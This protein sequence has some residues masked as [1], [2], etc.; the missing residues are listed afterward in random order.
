MR[1]RSNKGTGRRRRRPGRWLAAVCLLVPL[2]TGCKKCAATAIEVVPAVVDLAT[3]P[4]MPT[5]FEVEARLW[6]GPATGRRSVGESPECALT[7]SASQSWLQLVSVDGQRATFSIGKG[8]HPATPA[9]VKVKAGE[10]T[11]TPGAEVRVVP[12]TIAGQDVVSE[13]YTAG[14]SPAAVVVNGDRAASGGSPDV[15]LSAFVRTATPG[16]AN[17]SGGDPAWGVAV[18]DARHAMTMVPVTWTPSGD[19]VNVSSLQGSPLLLPVVLRVIIGGTGDLTALRTQVLNTAL[20]DISAANVMLAEN[21]VGVALEVKD[22]VAVTTSDALTKVSDC[23]AG[24]A[25]TDPGDWPGTLH[26]TYVNTMGSLTGF[27]CAGTDARPQSAIYVSWENHSPTTFAHEVGHA[28]GLTVPGQ[29]HSDRLAGFDATNLMT[30]G[31]SDLDPMGR[32]RFTV[33]QAFRMNAD[34]GSWLNRAHDP[35]T[36]PPVRRQEAPRL[37]CQCDEADPTHLCPRQVEDVAPPSGS[38]GAFNPWDCHDQ[39][40]LPEV[41]SGEDPVGLLAGRR[42]R[43]EIGDCSIATQRNWAVRFEQTYLEFDNMTRPGGCPSW[44]AIFF[45]HHEVLYRE[46]HESPDAQ[47][48]DATEQLPIGDGILP[49]DAGGLPKVTVTVDL[50]YKSDAASDTRVDAD[51]AEAGRVF[52]EDNRSGIVLEFS[53]HTSLPAPCPP[54]LSEGITV[55]YSA[56]V[57]GEG[58]RS[59]R[60]IQVSAD[61]E[62]EHT[63]SH[64]LGQ[65]LGLKALAPDDPVLPLN[66]MRRLPE[67]RGDRLTLG[68]VFRINAFLRPTE[69]PDCASDASRCPTLDADVTP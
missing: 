45:K 57:A 55:C 9:F 10:K 26:V 8:L 68:Q 56:A 31:T 35:A 42:W 5:T 40:T 61:H 52:G 47:W 24:D 15:W 51:I 30:S 67:D 39:L 7:W 46:L 49:M 44:T 6:S 63:F 13:A 21:R 38:P 50:Y 58:I 28:L 54:S 29:G 60:E 65:A 48:S 36:G 37:A 19:V 16:K 27:T 64:L 3:D 53:R 66:V 20:A 23:L 69:L 22:Q 32:R 1:R 59:G 2:A 41:E 43:A 25:Y 14:I 12:A 34:A 62:D 4:L 17:G 18:L 33:G 11:S